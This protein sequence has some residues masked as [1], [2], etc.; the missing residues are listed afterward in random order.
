M[1]VYLGDIY[2]EVTGLRQMIQRVE[3]GQ[4]D[5]LLSVRH[6]SDPE[7]IRKN[8]TVELDGLG[9]VKRVVEKPD[10]PV[11]DLKGCGLYLFSRNVFEAIRQ[12]PRSQLRNEFEITDSIQTLIDGAERVG[13]VENIDWDIN[14]TFD[15]DLLE[16]NLRTLRQSGEL[17][18]VGRDCEIHP[19]AR[20]ERCVLGDGVRIT[21]PV[22]LT[23]SLILSD[24]V[25]EREM[26]AEQVIVA[27]GQVIQVSI[28]L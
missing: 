8:F 6:E 2:F 28:D 26:R 18:L 3:E 13:I 4:V 25:V 17:N 5:S 21:C 12:T 16:C 9:L 10:V 7:M 22:V 23:D 15:A 1:L 24:T 14:L 19:E 20:L 11:N 27:P